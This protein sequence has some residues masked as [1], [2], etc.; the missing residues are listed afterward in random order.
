MMGLIQIV[1]G[2]Q[3]TID[4]SVGNIVAQGGCSSTGITLGSS[5]AFSETVTD[6][7][8]LASADG[9]ADTGCDFDILNL[10][11]SQ[12]VPAEQASDSYDIDMTLTLVAI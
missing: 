3:L 11:V 7:I 9:T 10:D 5:S 2:G 1:W 12:S 4:P 8:T 6:A